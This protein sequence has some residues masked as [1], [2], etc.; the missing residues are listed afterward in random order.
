[1]AGPVK[2]VTRVRA[3]RRDKGKPLWTPRDLE[4]LAW[5]AEQYGVRR[6]HLAVLLGRAAQAETKT[7]GR[8]AD[9]TVKDWVQRWRRAGIVESAGVLAGEPGWVWVTRN[10]LEH[11]ELDYRFWEPK[12]RGLAH[13]H[14][15]NQAR[16]W[17][18]QQQPAAM[19]RSERQMR[20]E[21]PFV[22]NQAHPEHQPDAEVQMGT[23]TVA[24]E[25]ERSAKYAKRLPSILYGLARTYNGIWYFCSPATQ[26][27]LQRAIAELNP[28]ALRQKFSVVPLR[29]LGQRA[30]RPTVSP[31][32]P[33][34]ERQD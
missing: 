18:E 27:E 4:V 30:R 11:L 8:L 32:P 1:M 12:E 29:L 2:E 26:G 3:P 23:Q 6:D 24:I 5:I 10:G 22:G 33:Q 21:R 14:A 15:V 25:V 20:S 17:V 13:L 19:W 34:E 7:P 9:T 28:P 16:L 31:A